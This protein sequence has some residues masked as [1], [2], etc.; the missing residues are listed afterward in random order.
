VKKTFK[1]EQVKAMVWACFTG[2]RLRPLMSYDEGGIGSIEYQ[3]IL[4]DSIFSLIDDLLDP[5]EDPKGVSIF[6][7]NIFLFMQD[8][9]SCHEVVT[10]IS[11]PQS[12]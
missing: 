2:E 7:D 1:S 8:N 3:D 12:Y 9:A 5:S 4:H 10:S 11:G 6:H